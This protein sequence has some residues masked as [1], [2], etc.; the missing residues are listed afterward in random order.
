VRA[1]ID[2]NVLVSGLI[3]AAGSPGRIVDLLRSGVLEITVD[4]RILAEYKDVLRRDYFRVYFSERNCE[5]IIAYLHKNSHY[6]S[7]HLVIQDMPDPGDAPFLEVALST[8]DPLV[9]GNK[10]HY[11]RGK[12]GNCQVLDPGEFLGAFFS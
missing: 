12:R 2:T 4:D 7:S 8:G 11:P 6:I 10:R 1:V 3:N 5:D 9:T